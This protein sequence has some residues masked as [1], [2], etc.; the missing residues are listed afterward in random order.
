MRQ[1]SILLFVLFFVTFSCKEYT[2]FNYDAEEPENTLSVSGLVCNIFT[3]QPVD[4]ALI[5][6]G[7]QR[8]LTDECGQYR[9]TYFI[10]ID[11]ERN[12]PVKVKITA[13]NYEPDSSRIIAAS[14]KRI[15]DFSLIYVAPIIRKAKLEQRKDDDFI[16]FFCEVEIHDYQGVADIKKVTGT[17]IYEYPNHSGY[18]SK[19]IALHFSE[20]LSDT[21]AVYNCEVPFKIKDALD[22]TWN[23]PRKDRIFY[24]L[25]EDNEGNRDNKMFRNN[26]QVDY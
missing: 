25:A 24:I 1:A 8:T 6:I 7:T 9:L 3:N 11:D 5:Q 13:S 26:I 16:F 17:F 10:N 18:K 23:I 15:Y 19:A 12:K 21:N 20:Q 2:G 22:I 4:S 14:G